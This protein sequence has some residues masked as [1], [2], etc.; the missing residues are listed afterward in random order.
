MQAGVVSCY[1]WFL[2]LVALEA[3]E[4]EDIQ[5]NLF[6][7]TYRSFIGIDDQSAVDI[8]ISIFAVDRSMDRKRA[9]Q[10]VVDYRVSLNA[11]WI[12]A[13]MLSSLARASE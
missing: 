1:T 13:R 8:K 2:D 5:C 7:S 6:Q 12:S 11:V 3:T 4:F 9:Q 10:K